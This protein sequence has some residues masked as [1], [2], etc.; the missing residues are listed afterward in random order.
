MIYTTSDGIDVVG[1]GSKSGIYWALNRDTG[2]LIWSYDTGA[3]NS[4][5]GCGFGSSMDNNS[6]YVGNS[7]TGADVVTMSDGSTCGGGF[8]T[9]IDKRT[10]QLRWK[11]CDPIAN[12]FY[13]PPPQHPFDNMAPGRIP[14]SYSS[15]FAPVTTNA[16]GL[17]FVGSMDPRGAVYAL[18][19]ATGQIVW[20]YYLGGSVGASATIVDGY[21]LWGSGYTQWGRGSAS[22]TYRAFKLPNGTP[23]TTSAPTTT[24]VSP[25]T[26]NSPNTPTTTTTP[27]PTVDHPTDCWTC[28][29]GY[30][31]WWLAGYQVAP[32]GD[33]CS[34]VDRATT[35]TT[36]PTT[37]KAP[38]T[39]TSSPTTTKTPTT[40]PAPTPE[41]PDNC[42]TCPAGFIHWWLAGYQATPDGDLCTCIDI[43]SVTTTTPPITTTA[44]PTSTKVC[45]AGYTLNAD[46]CYRLFTQSLT[47]DG[48]KEHCRQHGGYLASIT[49]WQQNSWVQQFVPK[50]VAEF[51][52]G[53]ARANENAAFQWDDKRNW[54]YSNFDNNEPKRWGDRISFMRTEQFGTAGK[55]R[56]ITNAYLKPFLCGAKATDAQ[57]SISR[58]NLKSLKGLVDTEQVVSSGGSQHT[59]MFVT[60]AVTMM[61][62]L[63]GYV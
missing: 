19:S 51:F 60:A 43:N 63:I 33:R 22:R 45:P 26:T 56:A 48:A 52:I 30:I 31:H 3:G 7:N 49:T 42:W 61:L 59:L 54:G 47:Y 16:A 29:S 18:N 34:C 15:A 50:S 37:T 55:W 13:V 12:P 27:A 4:G 62:L 46:Y 38:T 57:R 2:A 58:K 23:T 41:H 53:G 17:V 24:T 36:A 21:L 35:T 1:G 5:G 8:W 44:P 28:P 20:T 40:T 32:D 6:I 39:T 10:G 25:T 14:A 9:S 11:V